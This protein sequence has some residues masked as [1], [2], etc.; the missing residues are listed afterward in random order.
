MKILQFILIGLIVP[1][2]C[3]KSTEIPTF[4]KSQGVKWNTGDS[5]YI[6]VRHAE[7]QSGDDPMLTDEGEIRAR[8]LA[9]LIEGLEDFSVYSSDYKRTKAT[10]APII[11]QYNKEL[12]IYDPRKLGD[13]ANTLRESKNAT[14]LIAGHSN[15]TPQ[16]A[17]KLCNC[18][19]FPAIDESDYT[20]IYVVVQSDSISRTF[21][22][23]Y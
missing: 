20:N 2:M 18:D 6:L 7:K 15:T 12:N 3:T 8:N 19:V 21:L 10:V 9:K 1:F 13:F 22:L 5:V 16:L 11:N 4:F 14:F 23:N 17:N